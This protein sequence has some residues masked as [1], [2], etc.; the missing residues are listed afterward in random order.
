MRPVEIYDKLKKDVIGQEETPRLRHPLRKA[1]V[2]LHVRQV[3]L[4]R[5][6]HLAVRIG[7][8]QDPAFDQI[9]PGDRQR[10]PGRRFLHLIGCLSA[11]D[12][13]DDGMSHGLL[14]SPAGAGSGITKS[15][16]TFPS[17]PGKAIARPL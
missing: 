15:F 17:P 11:Q 16:R 4:A 6:A 8:Q 7:S 14:S 9:L 2:L 12:A 10:S 1:Y 13:F 5:E 3:L